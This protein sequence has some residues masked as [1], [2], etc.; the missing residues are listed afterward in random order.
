MSSDHDWR[1][2]GTRKRGLTAN[3]ACDLCFHARA[4]VST[5]A[6]YWSG[7]R[8]GTAPPFISW[9]V[10]D[11]GDRRERCRIRRL[12]ALGRAYTSSTRHS[13]RLTYVLRAIDMY[14]LSGNLL[15]YLFTVCMLRQYDMMR[16]PPTEQKDTNIARGTVETR[17]VF[18]ELQS[19]SGF[20]G[21]DERCHNLGRL[22]ERF[23]SMPIFD[24][25]YWWAVQ[26]AV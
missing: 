17:D 22:T 9:R 23:A 24:R 10:N 15:T 21:G 26:S 6:R 8:K 19:L 5:S 16:C 18:W 14:F 11:Y 13:N 20:A 3:E 12:S 25:C 2:S 4:T 7:D 1:R